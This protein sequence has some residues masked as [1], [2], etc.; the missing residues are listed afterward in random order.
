[1]EEATLPD[2]ETCLGALEIVAREGW[3]CKAAWSSCKSVHAFATPSKVVIRSSTNKAIATAVLARP[4]IKALRLQGNIS[5]TPPLPAGLQS[6]ELSRYCGILDELPPTL[7]SL[8]V[9][10]WRGAPGIAC[11]VRALEAAPAGLQH[12]NLNRKEYQ[13]WAEVDELEGAQCPPGVTT[14]RLQGMGWRMKLPSQLHTL[15][16]SLCTISTELQLPDSVRHLEFSS[17]VIR[18][19]LLLNEGLQRLQ[20]AERTRCQSLIELPSTLTHLKILDDS[21]T[22][23][24]ELPPS[25]M[26]LEISHDMIEPLSNPLSSALQYA[27][28]SF[29][30]SSPLGTPLPD[31]LHTLVLGPFFNFP[32]GPL[33]ATLRK[34]FFES[35]E[36]CPSLYEHPLELPS[37]LL[38]LQLPDMYNSST[39]LPDFIE[40][41]VMGARFDQPLIGGSL[42]TNLTSLTMGARFNRSLGVL[43]QSLSELVIGAAF[44]KPLGPLPQQLVTLDLSLAAAFDHDLPPLTELPAGLQLLRIR[45]D[46]EAR[47]RCSKLKIERV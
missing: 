19:T 21:G 41:L 38:H 16:L 25:L 20:M 28:L 14:L 46:W 8:A 12:L 31:A 15:S 32:L 7:T 29:I 39:A 34:L 1:M 9:F 11:V 4:L 23:L 44:N 18:G 3:L 22:L 35:Q 36:D 26:R 30:Y 42:P 27:R 40:Q 43:P 13:E 2:V 33:P 24:G 10:A 45:K 47:H 5:S 6:L 37:Q 17:C